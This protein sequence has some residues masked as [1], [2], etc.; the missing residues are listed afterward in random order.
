M[1]ENGHFMVLLLRR[2]R[3]LESDARSESIVRRIVNKE[4]EH[5]G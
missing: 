1:T 4:L 3:K 2:L 5:E